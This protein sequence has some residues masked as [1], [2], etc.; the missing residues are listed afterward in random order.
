MLGV[1]LF[2]EATLPLRVVQPNFISAV[3]RALVQVDNPFIVGVVSE[4]FLDTF[5]LPFLFM[6]CLSLN[7]FLENIQN[8]AQVR[9]Y[10]GSDSDNRQLRF[11]TVGTT[12]EVRLLYDISHILFFFLTMEEDV[13]FICVWLYMFVP[14]MWCC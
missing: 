13:K 5:P 6:G 4:H 1:V 8:L 12:A 11:A 7:L 9:A 14:I 3:E 2:P 10:R